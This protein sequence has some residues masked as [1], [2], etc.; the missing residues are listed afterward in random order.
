MRKTDKGYYEEKKDSLYL[1]YYID[2]LDGTL[3]IYEVPFAYRT[4]PAYI[5]AFRAYVTIWDG[6]SEANRKKLETKL[7][8]TQL[9]NDILEAERLGMYSRAMTLRSTYTD[10][11]L[12][13]RLTD[14]EG[15][16]C[17]CDSIWQEKETG[18]GVG[19]A[20]HCE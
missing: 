2:L 17:N 4:K 12:E 10:L 8:E 14:K 11:F 5:H 13:F 9:L 18:M 7:I 20:N 3:K 1:Q 6:S 16:R 15:R 19:G